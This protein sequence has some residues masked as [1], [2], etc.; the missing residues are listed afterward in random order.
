MSTV[1]ETVFINR[2]NVIRL[3]LYE[4][5]VL[6]QTA[7]PA[8]VPTRW[9]L[10]INSSPITEIDS[11]TYPM[12]FG[13]DSATSTLE[14]ALGSLLTTAMSYTACTLVLYA[15]Q[16][17]EGVV[18]FNPSCSPDKLLIRVCNLT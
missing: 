10:K 18:W 7:Y 8:V 1:K 17:P 5:G 11:D 14:L 9:V 3:V 4:D 6:F 15:A 13:W 2:N 12:V 16:W